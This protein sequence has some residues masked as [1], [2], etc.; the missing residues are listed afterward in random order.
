MRSVWQQLTTLTLLLASSV[1]IANPCERYLTG[2]PLDSYNPRGKPIGDDDS[3]FP[4][5]VRRA[6]FAKEIEKLNP[7]QFPKEIQAI[8]TSL[9]QISDTITSDGFSFF[10][11]D[12]HGVIVAILNDRSFV[13]SEV[14]TSGMQMKLLAKDSDVALWK[15]MSL[16]DPKEIM[17][18]KF[19]HTH[20]LRT[21][22]G[23]EIGLVVS[24]EDVQGTRDAQRKLFNRYGVNVPWDII[25]IPIDAG[26][27]SSYT[28]PAIQ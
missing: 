28:E 22:P 6:T 11:G 27:V 20:P 23:L 5:D 15:L 12:E 24:P 3:G 16:I 25:A 1:A 14:F 19:F 26:F 8:M 4:W 2:Q 13:K 21:R 10:S 18:M 7:N 9:I 17:R